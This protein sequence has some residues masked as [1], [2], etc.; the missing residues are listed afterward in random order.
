M[1]GGTDTCGD[2][3]SRGWEGRIWVP[4]GVPSGMDPGLVFLCKRG[5]CSLP[6]RSAEDT[7]HHS[8]KGGS[9]APAKR[10]TLSRWKCP[11]PQLQEP[12]ASCPSRPPALSRPLLPVRSDPPLSHLASFLRP[13][14]LCSCQCPLTHGR[15]PQALTPPHSSPRKRHGL[16]QRH[17]LCDTFRSTRGS[18]SCPLL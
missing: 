5:Q 11:C 15:L 9:P 7:G 13:P 4:A 2:I 3:S 1:A 10:G 6:P 14:F 17:L 8:P 18:E 16:V 12:L